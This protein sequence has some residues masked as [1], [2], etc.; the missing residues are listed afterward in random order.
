MERFRKM[1]DKI[2]KIP[3]IYLTYVIDPITKH[4]IIIFQN[5]AVGEDFEK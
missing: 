2:F 3:L 4:E 1:T 5:Y